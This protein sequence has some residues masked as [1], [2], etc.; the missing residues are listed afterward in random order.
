MKKLFSLL[1]VAALLT[2]A[3]CGS[4]ND[5][6]SPE[7]SGSTGGGSAKATEI[8]ILMGKPEI[9]KEFEA[10]V[11]DF[12]NETGVKVTIIP[13]A[14]ANAFERMTSLYSS[15]NAP[16]IMMMASE[17]ETFKDRLLD[18]S[19]QP[20][21]E[22]VQEGMTDFVAVDGGIY[23]QPVTV[24]AFGFIYNKGILDQ[25]VGG[26]FDPAAVSTH[27]EFR[28][29]LEQID[30]LDGAS[31]IHVSP[32]DW[33]LGAH[34][35]NPFFAAQSSDRDER[36]Q[37][38]QDML[39]GNVT[40]SDNEVFNNWL[41]T[42]ELMKEY[43][44]V[45]NSPLSPQYDDGPLALASGKVGLWFMGNWAYPQLHEIDPEGEYGFLP[46][47]VSND[48]SH[49]GNNEISVGVPSYWV[50]DASQSTTDQQ[51]AA[52]AFLNWL[53]SSESGQNHY[54]NNLNFIP[55]FDSI[56]VQPEDSLSLSILSYMEG[57]NTLEWMNSYYPA[58]GWASMGASM[59]KFL[60]DNID[61][62]GLIQEFENYWKN[63]KK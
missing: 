40:L 5:Q 48:A 1:V 13:L 7:T 56:T 54:V 34:L 46:V 10:A 28:S 20:W 21:V 17:F 49:F 39:D 2:L 38:M 26:D 57:N 44:S 61:R 37:F 12:S 6:T 52:N 51:E 31:A 25:A 63:A 22:T 42:F 47:P 16:T 36:H 43:N 23:G 11:A 45:K 29:L 35:S 60:A 30:A 27:D 50:I 41:T 53:V 58:D 15:G 4:G 8:T 9:A 19:D 33:S 3:A 18:L 62:E 24:E 32:M 59:Q 14:G 55:V